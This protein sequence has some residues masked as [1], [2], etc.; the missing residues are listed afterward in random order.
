LA[1]HKKYER[2]ESDETIDI[3]GSNLTGLLQAIQRGHHSDFSALFPA[4]ILARRPE[5]KSKAVKRLTIIGMFLGRGR[6]IS[7]VIFVVPL[8]AF[9]KVRGRG[10]SSF[11]LTCRGNKVYWPLHGAA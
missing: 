2:L 10:G 6:M 9:P 3:H 5:S 7:L 11:V 1:N 8:R 4:T